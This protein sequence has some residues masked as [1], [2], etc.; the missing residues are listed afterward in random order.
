MTWPGDTVDQEGGTRWILRSSGDW[1][2]IREPNEEELAYGRQLV[3][4]GWY[5]T[6]RKYRAVA[7]L[8]PGVTVADALRGAMLAESHRAGQHELREHEEKWIRH[9]VG[10]GGA[11]DYYLRTFSD[12]DRRRLGL[13]IARELSIPAFAAFRKAGGDTAD[14]VEQ[15]G[16]VAYGVRRPARWKNPPDRPGSLAIAYYPED[17]PRGNVD[18]FGAVTRKP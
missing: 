2:E 9:I 4:E 5:Q 1:L 16:S 18:R 3:A 13:D 14:A 11:L 10:W 15:L 6:S 12:K 7:R 17:V 8:P